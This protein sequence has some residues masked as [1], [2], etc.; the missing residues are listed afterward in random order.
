MTSL[1]NLLTTLIV[2]SPGTHS[3]VRQPVQHS[4][5]GPRMRGTYRLSP[6]TLVLAL[7]SVHNIPTQILTSV[8]TFTPACTS[9]VVRVVS[10]IRTKVL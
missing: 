5:V 9:P 7:N 10:W 6:R 3:A 1:I 4:L 8:I 2:L